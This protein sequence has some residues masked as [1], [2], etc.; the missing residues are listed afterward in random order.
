M[1]FPEMDASERHFA[2]PRITIP[3]RQEMPT[4]RGHVRI[5]EIDRGFTGDVV[6]TRNPR[7]DEVEQG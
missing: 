2:H 3:V 4:T 1:W 7:Q 6:L 5:R